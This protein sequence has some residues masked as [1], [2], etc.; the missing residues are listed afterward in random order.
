MS[1]IYDVNGA[2]I[3]ASVSEREMPISAFFR[4][5]QSF[6]PSPHMPTSSLRNLFKD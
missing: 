4:A 3:E 5:A 6:A 1:Y 2:A